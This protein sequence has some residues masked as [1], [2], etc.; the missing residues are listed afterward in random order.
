MLILLTKKRRRNRCI[1]KIEPIEF[2]DEFDVENVKEQKELK[3]DSKVVGLS[4]WKDRIANNQ[5]GEDHRWNGF[6]GEISSLF[7]NV[8]TLRYLL[9]IQIDIACQ[10]VGI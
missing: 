9:D 2:R 5:C 7:L 8:V 3:N 1:L 4:N 6:E 10:L